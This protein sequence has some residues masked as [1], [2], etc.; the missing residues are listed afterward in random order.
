MADFPI[1]AVIK[2]REGELLPV[3]VELPIHTSHV[4]D[5]RDASGSA[6]LLEGDGEASTLLDLGQPEVVI[7]VSRAAVSWDCV[8]AFALVKHSGSFSVELFQWLA[9]LNE[10]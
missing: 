8:V 10:Q 6:L 5:G 4:V 2:S 1:A 3:G 9:G 7:E